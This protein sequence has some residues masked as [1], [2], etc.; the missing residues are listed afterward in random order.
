MDKQR[1]YFYGFIAGFV[2][3][4]LPVPHFF[5][6]EDIIDIVDVVFQYSGFI[7]LMVC[8]FPL[9]IEVFRNFYHR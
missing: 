6:W 2:L 1:T 9:V 7:L 3:I 4:I 8:V 5:F